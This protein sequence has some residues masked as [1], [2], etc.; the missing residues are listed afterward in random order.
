MTNSKQHPLH[1]FMEALSMRECGQGENRIWDFLNE[2][3]K[4]DY[5]TDNI[6]DLVMTYP[7][8]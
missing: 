5:L 3:L 2:Q 4:S 7:Q 8:N 6:F 1:I